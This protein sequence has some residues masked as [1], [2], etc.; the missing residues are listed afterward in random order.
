[1]VLLICLNVIKANSPTGD[2]PLFETVAYS[3]YAIQRFFEK[4]EKQPWFKNTLFVITAD[5]TS[6]N[7]YP[8]YVTDLG[9][10]NVPVIFLCPWASRVEGL[11]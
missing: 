9:Y 8:E 2:D 3:D 4:A 10:Y 5:H 6:G 7:C 11:G 1:M